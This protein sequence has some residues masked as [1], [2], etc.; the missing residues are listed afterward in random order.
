MALHEVF[1]SSTC[2]PCVAGNR[3]TDENIFPKYDP[4]QYAVIKYQMSWPGTG[5]PYTTAEGNVRRSLYAVNSI[6]NMQV[7]GGWNGN[8]SSY[9]TALFDQFT[10][11]P[12]YI[13]IESTHTINFKK[14]TVDV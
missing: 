4:S 13:K 14:V 10:G 6:P 7:D 3:N 8:A 2:G 11:K 12:A 1:T 5:D 9:T